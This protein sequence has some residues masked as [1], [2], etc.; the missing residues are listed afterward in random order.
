MIRVLMVGMHNKI[1]GVETF[2][3]NYYHHI[4]REKVQFDF[5]NMFDQ[6]CFQEEICSLGGRI[7]SIP[8]VKRNPIGYY[9]GLKKIIKENNYKIVYVNMLSAA[10]ILP[11]K[12]SKTLKV[13]NIIA[14]AHNTGVPKGA[15]R[16]ILD[17]LNKKTLRKNATDFLASS[18][19]AAEWMF[20]K[21]ISYQII[22]NAI[23]IEKFEY[24]EATRKN[25]RK[26]LGIENDFVIG[27]VGRF[28]QQK[29]HSFLIEVFKS[30]SKKVKNAKLLLIGEG[31][32]KDSIIKK[33]KEYN[34]EKKV[35]FI[36]PVSNVND[37]MQAM[38]VF[39][40]P[41]IFEG[42][43]IVLIEAQ[44]AGLRCYAADNIPTVANVFKKITY[45]PLEEEQWINA[46]EKEIENAGY[47]RVITKEEKRNCHYNIQEE[48]K[49]MQKYLE[50]VI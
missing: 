20:G 25:I 23:E 24:N 12:I 16:K 26:K 48:A 2:L 42:L 7:Y 31:E 38:D 14:H 27:H 47:N 40:L 5:V 21:D 46:I 39:V 30:A 29:N 19:E 37:Y 43:G 11:I 50:S 9:L 8:N 15:L 35:I 44:S 28:C 13:P 32:L 18:K 41:S 33:V 36:D 3:I 6:L 49:K 22:Y 10:N 4:D 17:K 1:G 45:L 34:L